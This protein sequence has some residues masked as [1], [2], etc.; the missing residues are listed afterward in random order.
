MCCECRK[1][2]PAA[3]DPAYCDGAYPAGTYGTCRRGFACGSCKD[4]V[5]A[6]HG[7]YFCKLQVYAADKSEDVTITGV[8]LMYHPRNDAKQPG[9]SYFEAS[10]RLLRGEAEAR[11]PESELP[12]NFKCLQLSKIHGLK[13]KAE[14][15]AGARGL[16]FDVNIQLHRRAPTTTRALVPTRTRRFDTLIP[17]GIYTSTAMDVLHVIYIGV[18]PKFAKMLD[19]LF[20]GNLRDPEDKVKTYEDVHQRLEDRL[21]AMPRMVD[22]HHSLMHFTF[23]WWAGRSGLSKGDDWLNLFEQLLFLYIDDNILLPDHDMRQKV[24]RLHVEFYGLIREVK[25]K[26]WRSGRELN[27]MKD[28]MT[29]FV[30]ELE[31]FHDLVPTKA[32]S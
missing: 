18:V 30:N 15:L 25:R 29:R 12:V 1:E 9:A 22:G 20:V 28:R 11:T 6:D 4:K 14:Q 16:R 3:E 24:V 2:I 7:A 26:V 23:G 27:D 8:N 32:S 5:C 17:G 19:A 13:G 31:W 21:A 10:R